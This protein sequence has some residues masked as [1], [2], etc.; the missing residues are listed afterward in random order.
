VA[1]TLGLRLTGQPDTNYVLEE[2]TRLG[3]WSDLA[4]LRTGVNG[5]V[6]YADTEA[7]TRE[8]R[9]FRARLAP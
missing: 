4:T 5:S 7:M 3:E 8:R 6:S 9:Y 1:G 2:A